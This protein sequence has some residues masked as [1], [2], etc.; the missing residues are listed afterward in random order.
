MP[1]YLIA[2]GGV[3]GVTAAQALRQLDATAEICLLGEESYPYYYRPRLW[4]YLAG[5]MDTATLFYRPVEWYASQKILLRLQTPVTAINPPEHQVT[6][7]TGEKL[8][9]DRLLLTTGARS[10]IPPVPGAGKTGVFTLRTLDD[11]VAIRAYA[12]GHRRAVVMGGGL[13]GLETAR[14]LVSAGLEVT[15]VEVAPYL[16]PKQMDREGAQVLQRRLEEMG[17]QIVTGSQAAS[18]AGEDSVTGIRIKDGATIP[19]EM[20]LFSTG[21]VPR[22]ELAKAAGLT[23]ERGV[24]V[25]E[26]LQTS[27]EDVFAAG[28]AAEFNFC[29]YGLMPAAGRPPITAPC[30]RPR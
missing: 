22:I 30:P 17:L 19:C 11:A 6:L 24:I 2:G 4:E 18:I 20:A 3:A 29:V 12:A 27:A 25:D 15:V 10:F 1:R 14:A 23:A 28:D 8:S 21:I 9:Y 13:L 16:L 7:P 5:G 26:Y